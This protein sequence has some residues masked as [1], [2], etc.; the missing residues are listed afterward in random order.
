MRAAPLPLEGQAWELKTVESQHI[1]RVFIGNQWWTLRLHDT[2]WSRARREACEKIASGE[3]AA[4]EF[5][6]YRR[7]AGEGRIE[8]RPAHD[9][10][11]YEIECKTVAWFPRERLEEHVS[12]DKLRRARAN[13][14]APG[15]R[16]RSIE[17][18]DISNLRRAIRTNWISFPA[19]VPTFP[20]CGQP[21]LQRRITQLYFVMGWSCARIA[22]RY[23]LDQDRVRGILNTWKWRAANAGYLEHVPGADLMTQLA[24]LASSVH[25]DC[26]DQQAPASCPVP[27]PH[28]GTSGGGE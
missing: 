10:P 15:V 21:D 20:G 14:P 25:P 13:R 24:M 1:L 2:R 19:Q 12:G 8:N 6:L 27:V 11:P 22:A 28:G 9:L 7:P 5:L 18:L 23:G 3:V 26:V 4:G 17:D 16:D